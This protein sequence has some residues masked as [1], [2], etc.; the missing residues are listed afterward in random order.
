MNKG[1]LLDILIIIGAVFTSTSALYF[2]LSDNTLAVEPQINSSGRF[3]ATP[4]EH[5]PD[6]ESEDPLR[7]GLYE[8]NSK[9]EV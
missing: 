3:L 4:Y 2:Y 5:A 9:L 1:K 6:F 7:Y 8:I